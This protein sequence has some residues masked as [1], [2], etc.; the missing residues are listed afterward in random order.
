MQG[1][2]TMNRN[3]MITGV[4]AGTVVALLLYMSFHVKS[5][6]AATAVAVLKTSGMTCGSCSEKITGALKAVNGVTHTEVDLGGGYVIVGFDAAATTPESLAAQVSKTGYGS[7]VQ[8]VLTPKQFK[9]I[10]GRDLG[11]LAQAGG[12]CGC[13]S[14]GGPAKPQ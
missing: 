1:N 2:I 13:C 6:T 11:R 4:I 10:T 8:E 9:E 3:K 14:G 7:T 12:G 5:A